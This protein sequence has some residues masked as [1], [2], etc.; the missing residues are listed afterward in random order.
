VVG[1]P[2]EPAR[3]GTGRGVARQLVSTGLDRCANL[4][5]CCSRR[6]ETHRLA[7]I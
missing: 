7:A 5:S 6:D 3:A 2:R 4:E 1:G